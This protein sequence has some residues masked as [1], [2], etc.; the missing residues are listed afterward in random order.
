MAKK[1]KSEEQL[2]E[3]NFEVSSLDEVKDENGNGVFHMRT[4]TKIITAISAAILLIATVLIYL[5][6]ENYFDAQMWQVA[7]WGLCG[8]LSLYAIFARSI[9]ALL[10]NIVLFFGISFFPA[11][12]SSYKTFQPVIEKFSNSEEKSEVETPPTV[13]EKPAEKI[14]TPS[15]VEEKPAEKVEKSSKTEDKSEQKNSDDEKIPT[16]PLPT[17]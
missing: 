2:E 17:I 9:A 8:I 7:I 5:T 3:A 13:E 6:V 10:L 4:K 16:P 15:N 11:W 1:N 14:E 12:H